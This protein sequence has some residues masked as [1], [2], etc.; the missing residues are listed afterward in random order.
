MLIAICGRYLNVLG[1]SMRGNGKTLSAV[2]FA[3]NEH[4]K[5]REIYTNFYTSFSKLY[6][7]NDLIEMFSNGS[8]SNV[9]VVIDEAQIYLN[10]SG[11]S[12]KA[13]KAMITNFIAQTRKSNV[14]VI[15]T[16]QR[17]MQLHKELREQCDVILLASKYHYNARGVT[18]ACTVDNCTRP[19]VVRLFNMNTSKFLPFV[20]DCQKI[21]ELYNSNEIVLDN[22]EI[23][24]QKTK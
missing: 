20:L 5:G 15:L 11:I 8:L 17:F 4:D 24:T 7:M 9:L 21:G 1:T 14:D 3:K 13:R 18:D 19:H 12:V 23:P 2:F 6:K 10:N 16:T 22:Y